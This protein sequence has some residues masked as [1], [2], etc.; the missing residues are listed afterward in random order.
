MEDLQQ[1]SKNDLQDRLFNFVVDVIIQIRNLPNGVE[2]NVISYQ[3]IKAATSTGANYEEAQGAVSKP[4]FAN[5]V[6]IA[7]KEMR[8]SNYWI[9]LV[10]AITEK[11]DEW[12]KMRQES[13]ELMKILGSIYSKTSVK[14]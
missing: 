14:R 9:R 1:N 3:L 13:A 11:N 12:K 5:K 10:I 6:G 7:L 4:D 8:E 2:Y